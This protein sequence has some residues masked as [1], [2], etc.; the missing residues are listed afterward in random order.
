MRPVLRAATGMPRCRAC[1]WLT[2]SYAMA[3]AWCVSERRFHVDSERVSPISD[4]SIDP[5]WVSRGAA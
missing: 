4:C 2:S 5:E 3:M 1:I